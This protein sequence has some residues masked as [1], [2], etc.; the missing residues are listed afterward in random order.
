MFEAIARWLGIKKKSTQ[1]RLVQNEALA[2][3]RRAAAHEPLAQELAIVRIEERDGH[4]V[5]IVSSATVGIKLWVVIDDASGE[6]LDV[7]RGGIR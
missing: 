7:K 5:W 3:A 6:V 1:T 2:I 4:P